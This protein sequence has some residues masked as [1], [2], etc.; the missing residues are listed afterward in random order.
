MAGKKNKTMM[1]TLNYSSL[2]ENFSLLSQPIDKFSYLI[3]LGKKCEGIPDNLKIDENIDYEIWKSKLYIDTMSYL[4]GNYKSMIL[5]LTFADLLPV[6][7]ADF[8]MA[9][10]FFW[11]GAPVPPFG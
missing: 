5:A 10:F 3:D 6:Q 9:R 2:I 8:Y 11:S 1:G 4:A 7:T